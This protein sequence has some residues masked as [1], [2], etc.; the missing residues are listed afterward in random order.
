M[1]TQKAQKTEFVTVAVLS[2]A[3]SGRQYASMGC[4]EDTIGDAEVEG[5]LYGTGDGHEC[6][7]CADDGCPRAE[8]ITGLTGSVYSIRADAWAALQA[9]SDQGVNADYAED[10]VEAL[11]VDIAHRLRHA[12]DTHVLSKLA[13]HGFAEELCLGDFI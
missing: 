11:V 4:L 2:Y 13:S 8:A 7:E 10:T 12:H 1:K 6:D 9:Y 5:L 3:D